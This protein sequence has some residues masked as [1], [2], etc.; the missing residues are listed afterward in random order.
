MDKKNNKQTIRNI[1]LQG[2]MLAAILALQL[3]NLPN[4]ITGVIV[5]SIFIFTALYIGTRGAVVLCLLSPLGGILS[6]H[7]PAFMY[8]TLPIIAIGNLLLVSL[9]S[10]L[11]NKKLWLK[12][13]L[14]AFF[15]AVFIGLG[16]LVVMQ[17]LVTDKVG[18]WLV[19]PVLGIQFF[20][21]IPGIWLGITLFENLRKGNKMP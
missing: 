18:N 20:T 17:L 19:F 15:K 6:G 1:A 2:I 8:P 3:I 7:V 21:A 13:F 5:N 10:V 4:I 16:G 11:R 12:L 14:P 9:F